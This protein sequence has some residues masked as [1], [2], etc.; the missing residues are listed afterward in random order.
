MVHAFDIV[1]ISLILILSFQSVGGLTVNYL[2]TSFGELFTQA[3]AL[4]KDCDPADAESLR[5]IV[6]GKDC[7][8]AL[9]LNSKTIRIKVLLNIVSGLKDRIL[10]L[11][12]EAKTQIKK[13]D[14]A[15]RQR[16]SYEENYAKVKD[17]LVEADGLLHSDMLCPTNNVDIL[18]QQLVKV[19]WQLQSR[20]FRCCISVFLE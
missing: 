9:I 7:C 13:L 18:Q 1:N 20:V 17:W 5:K 11:N 10:S 19:R 12:E 16:K 3:N 2:E 4:D 14:D 6:S 15:L 8:F